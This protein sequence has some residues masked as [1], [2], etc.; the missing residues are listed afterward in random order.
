MKI[1]FSYLYLTYSVGL[2]VRAAGHIYGV[3]FECLSLLSDSCSVEIPYVPNL[4]AGTKVLH[5]VGILI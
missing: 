3:R 2:L 1:N 5:A 4:S